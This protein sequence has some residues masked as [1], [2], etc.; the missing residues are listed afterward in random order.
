[1]C[2]YGFMD[3][4]GLFLVFRG[5]LMVRNFFQVLS[6]VTSF[7]GNDPLG[8]IGVWSVARWFWVRVHQLAWGLFVWISCSPC[9]CMG[10]LQVFWLPPQ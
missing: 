9:A 7:K 4:C 3:R 5:K 10:S 1:M 6:Y 8:S 2:D